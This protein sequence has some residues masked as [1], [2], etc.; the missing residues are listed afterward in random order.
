MSGVAEPPQGPPVPALKRAVAA[1][2]RTPRRA[3]AGARVTETECPGGD[4][5][6]GHD[7]AVHGPSGHFV[8]LDRGKRRRVA[9]LTDPM[10]SAPL[11]RLLAR[12][13]VFVQN[14]A[15]ASPVDGA[16][17]ALGPAPCVG[18]HGAAIRRGFGE[19][20]G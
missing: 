9:G 12:A 19:G 18:E 6:R 3:D 10:D 1:S 8:R 2:H 11:H 4:F 14:F 15:S 5:A 17:P 7:A 13:G 16:A 20:R